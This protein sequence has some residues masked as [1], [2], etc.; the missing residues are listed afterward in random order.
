MPLDEVDGDLPDDL[1]ANRIVVVNAHLLMCASSCSSVTFAHN[2]CADE[3]RLLVLF[4]AL[5]YQVNAFYF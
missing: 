4:D 2:E 3:C 1:M 5:K